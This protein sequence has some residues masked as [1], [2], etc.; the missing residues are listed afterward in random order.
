MSSYGSD[1][2]DADPLRKIAAVHRSGWVFWPGMRLVR[3]PG[4]ELWNGPP[5]VPRSVTDRPWL[6]DWVSARP[7]PNAV[8]YD[9][10]SVQHVQPAHRCT[11]VRARESYPVQLCRRTWCSGGAC[12]RKGGGGHTNGGGTRRRAA[13]CASVPRCCHH[14]HPQPRVG[15]KGS[16]GGWLMAQLQLR[17]SIL[18]PG[19]GHRSHGACETAFA[20]P[21]PGA[22]RLS[23]GHSESFRSTLVRR[24]GASPRR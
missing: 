21:D 5:E 13:R 10:C 14:A 16:S 1:T 9:W 12:D 20:S 22:V 18:S 24:A 7:A 8:G 23:Q 4:P 19:A 15:L 2:A 17:R 6:E 3:D 11:D